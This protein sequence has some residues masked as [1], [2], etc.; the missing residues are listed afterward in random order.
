LPPEPAF[1][2]RARLRDKRHGLVKTLAGITGDTHREINARINR[3]TAVTSVADASI[4][5]LERAIEA[6]L[7]EL[8][9]ASRRRAG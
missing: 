4:E 2:R 1:K 8:N 7:A 9:Q 5:Q 3:K 6:L